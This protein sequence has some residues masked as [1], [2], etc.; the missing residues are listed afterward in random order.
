MQ[1]LKNVTMGDSSAIREIKDATMANTSA[2]QRLERQLNHLVAEFNRLEEEEFQSQL[3]AEGH[4]MIDEDDSSYLHYEH[5][6]ATTTF[7]SEVVFEKIVNEPSLEDPFEESSAQFE[8]DID[9]VPKQDEALLDSTPEIRHENGKTTEISF[10]NTSSSAAEK[11]EK[12]EHLEYIEH[13]EHTM[14]LPD[15]NMSTDNEMSTEAHSFIAIPL[16]T[17]HEPRV[18]VFQC[19]QMPSSPK[20][21][22]DRCTQE[23]KSRNHRLTKILRSKQVGHLRRRHI[24]SKG[25]QILKKK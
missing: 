5:V 3:M 17:F 24:F 8:F 19:L 10:P 16:E 25:Y 2:I 11:E 14:L 13:L 20:S 7:G 9:F 21:F 22:K 23:Q 15:P 12:G 4:Y 18:S 6:Q 1:E